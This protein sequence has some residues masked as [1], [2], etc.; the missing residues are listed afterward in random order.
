MA[1]QWH[2][3]SFRSYKC[4]PIGMLKQ[5]HIPFL[6]VQVVRCVDAGSCSLIVSP[7]PFGKFVDIVLHD[8]AVYGRWRGN[9]PVTS[10]LLV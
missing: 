7:W 10:S 8:E 2:V 1:R 5:V 4:I 6:L 3:P 9:N